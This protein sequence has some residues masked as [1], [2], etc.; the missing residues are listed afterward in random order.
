MEKQRTRTALIVL[1]LCCG[2][3]VLSMFHR[4]CP[5]IIAL[6]LG[7]DL[8]LDNAGLGLMSGAALLSYGL[9]QLPSGLLADRLGGRRSLALL[10]ALGGLCAMGFS[11]SHSA[12]AAVSFRFLEGVGLAVTIPAMVI[13]AGCYPPQSFGRAYSIFLSSGGIGT[14]LAARPLAELN[15]LW[16]WRLSII[17]FG[18][19]TLALA[20]AVW[21]LIR[22]PARAVPSPK[23][24]RPS[25]L[26]GIVRVLRT[27]QFWPMALWGMGIMGSYFAMFTLWWGPYLMQGCGLD[28]S[29]AS[30][31]LTAGAFMALLSQPAAGWLSD[32]VL[33]RR[34]L[35]LIIGA[36]IGLAA[37]LCMA[38]L[39]GY[40]GWTA[41]LLVIAFVAG[42]AMF[43]P[44]TFAM[45]R[46]TF[47]MELIGTAG[48]L[49]NIFPP[50]WGVV[51]QKIYGLLLDAGGG[52]SPEA[53][54]LAAWAL[55]GNTL[56]AFV[57][58]LLMRETFGNRATPDA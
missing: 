54:R 41:T 6:D 34:R 15:A 12:A 35:P 27:R 2:G 44:L 58:A 26:R 31:V 17:G 5:A 23:A 55:V 38:L 16:G 56:L 32:S 3:Y 14:I 50:V 45:A 30:S 46:E 19:L 40:A 43:S 7:R 1:L 47:P 52:A 8:G 42:T 4:A 24:G 49:M 9:M 10:L 21:L 51:T 25:M 20:A 28:S 18:L 13:L 53:Y 36:G 57:C 22:E 33:R 48:G 29:T 39:Q 11:L 37:S